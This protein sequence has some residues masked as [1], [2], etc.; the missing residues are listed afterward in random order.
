MS[1]ALAGSA[2]ATVG[3]QRIHGKKTWR[4]F[5]FLFHRYITARLDRINDGFAK[6]RMLLDLHSRE[7]A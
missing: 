5:L 3:L 1:Q 2:G 7:T 4:L 6:L